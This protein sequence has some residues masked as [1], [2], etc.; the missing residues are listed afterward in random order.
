MLQ[1][2]LDQLKLAPTELIVLQPTTLCN[3]DCDYCF[4]P[5]RKDSN[6]LSMT[7]L[8]AIF[9][10]ISHDRL[11]GKTAAVCW[12][13]GE[14]TLLPESYFREA[15]AAIRMACPTTTFQFQIQTNGVRLDDAWYKFLAE[16]SV[17]VGISLD[18]DAYHND[19]RTDWAG[20]HTFDRVLRGLA[21]LQEAKINHYVMAVLSR[22]AL[23]DARSF[24]QFFK[25]LGVKKLCLN[26]TES[27]GGGVS[28]FLADDDIFDL[29]TMFYEQLWI[30]RAADSD[31]IWIREFASSIQGDPLSG[32]APAL[33]ESL[34]AGRI[35][36]V[37]WNG[38]VLPLTPDF[39]TVPRADVDKFVIGN[40]VREPLSANRRRETCKWLD[41]AASHLAQSCM[42]NCKYFSACGGGS[43][44]HRWAEFRSF[45]HHMT[46]TCKASIQARVR[47]VHQ[48]QA[49]LFA[50]EA[51]AGAPVTERSP[52]E[53]QSQH[54]GLAD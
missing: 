9:R 14:P 36:T 11:L 49:I 45:E 34:T 13:L 27:E 4:L 2:S 8:E 23:L 35:L 15:H 3:L 33:A 21:G 37:L 5:N 20:N 31:P 40:L 50:M 1:Y 12:H 6:T 52:V 29:M 43:P 25:Q 46:R 48:A 42:K 7:D 26:V 32:E 51:N 30:V 41:L 17:V 28:A 39:A 19:R 18:G 53:P 47:G 24:Y 22:R 38:D 54:H 10:N 16:G 44:A